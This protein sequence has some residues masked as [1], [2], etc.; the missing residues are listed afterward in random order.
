MWLSQT[1]FP[2]FQSYRYGF[3]KLLSLVHRAT[4]TVLFVMIIGV[5]KLLRIGSDTCIL[6]FSNYSYSF[7]SKNYLNESIHDY[8]LIVIVDGFNL[9]IIQ[10]AK[11]DPG[12]H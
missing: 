12:S 2:R 10:L 1:I 7:L 3:H 9:K 8:P 11:R 4:A 6:L 5:L